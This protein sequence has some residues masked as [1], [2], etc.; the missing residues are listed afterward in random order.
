MARYVCYIGYEIISG[1]AE[2]RCQFGKWRGNMPTCSKSTLIV[3]E[4]KSLAYLRFGLL[5]EICPFISTQS[6]LKK[7]M[8]GGNS[9]TK[10]HWNEPEIPSLHGDMVYFTCDNDQTIKG[11][12][13]TICL[14]GRW[15]PSG[16]LLFV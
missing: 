4:M 2:V 7:W 13:H 12:S 3:T 14:D 10:N 15:S 6:P 11:Y 9:E 8:I 1:A 5:A 16:K